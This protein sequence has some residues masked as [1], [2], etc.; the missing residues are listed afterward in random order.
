MPCLNISRS[1]CPNTLDPCDRQPFSAFPISY[2]SVP[3]WT[4]DPSHTEFLPVLPNPM[5]IPNI[6]IFCLV[7]RALVPYPSPVPPPIPFF[8]SH[9]LYQ[10]FSVPGHPCRIHVPQLESDSRFFSPLPQYIYQD[11][12]KL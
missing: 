8:T 2:L 11:C 7:L 4:Q 1:Q 3:H 5:P 9:L 6:C 12:M 10:H